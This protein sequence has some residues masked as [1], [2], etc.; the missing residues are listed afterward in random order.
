MT[1][2][3]G[4]EDRLRQLEGSSQDDLDYLYRQLSELSE[5]AARCGEGGIALVLRTI[6]VSKTG[7]EE[8]EKRLRR[9]N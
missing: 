4:L 1:K 9:T 5:L 8:I 6:V 7:S 3:K 2:D